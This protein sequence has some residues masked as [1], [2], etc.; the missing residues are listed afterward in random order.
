MNKPVQILYIH[1]WGSCFD[2]SSQKVQALNQ[3]GKVSGI[4]LDYTTMPDQIETS[5]RELVIQADVDLLV[6]TSLGGY[7]A[8]RIGAKCGVPFVAINP[9]IE[10]KVTLKKYVGKGTNYVGQKY[11]LSE[12]VVDKYSEIATDG[13]GLILLDEAD[14]VIDSIKTQ[15][16]LSQHYDVQMFE[17]GNHRF[18]HMTESLPL[19]KQFQ[20]RSEFVYGF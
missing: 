19:I 17:G 11:H 15:E 1:G 3:I 13:C 5:L 18:E 14:D 8:A 6:G 16:K 7:W 10:P 4:D 20:A 12:T 9:A 2:N